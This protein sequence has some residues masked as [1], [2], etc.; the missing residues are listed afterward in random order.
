MLTFVRDTDGNSVEAVHREEPRTGENR[1]DHLW[2]RVRDLDASRRFYETVA[3]VVGLSVRAR[4]G[5]QQRRGRL[6]RS[7]RGLIASSAHLPAFDF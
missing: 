5:R 2:I 4:P 1:L 7:R 3:P 6:P